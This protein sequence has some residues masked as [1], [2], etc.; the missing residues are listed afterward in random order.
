MAATGVFTVMLPLVL[1]VFF[2]FPLV[3]SVQSAFGCCD[4]RECMGGGG[5]GH[6]KVGPHNCIMKVYIAVLQITCA[7]FYLVAI[8]FYHRSIVLTEINHCKFRHSLLE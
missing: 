4:Q 8:C 6:I 1:L 5:G 7:L 3:E 2:V